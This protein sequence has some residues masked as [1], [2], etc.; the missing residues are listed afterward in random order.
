MAD[1][2]TWNEMEANLQKEPR[3]YSDFVYDTQTDGGCLTKFD[4]IDALI[5]NIND[6]VVGIADK[7]S[8]L[9]DLYQTF[10]DYDETMNTNKQKLQESVNAIKDAYNQVMSG[11]QQQVEELQKNDETLMEDLDNIN[12]LISKDSETDLASLADDVI[13]G[14]YGTGDER[15]AALGDNY[16]AVQDIVNKKLKGEWKEGD[17]PTTDTPTPTTETPTTETPVA[18]TPTTETP[19]VETP[20]TETPSTEVP[21][22]DTT[23]TTPTTEA[24]FM[25]STGQKSLEQLRSELGLFDGVNGNS[26][27]NNKFGSGDLAKN[28]TKVLNDIDIYG[29]SIGLSQKDKSNFAYMIGRESGYKTG[30]SNGQYTGLGQMS[31]GNI[32]TYAVDQNAYKAGNSMVQIDASYK[33]I[34]GRYGSIDNARKHWDSHG[35][36]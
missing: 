13:A 5:G 7:Y 32:S 11:M 25:P 16:E 30:A 20:V 28:Q 31:P 33:Y 23:T 1:V 9:Q 4:E 26:S 2:V 36:Y 19:V 3:T 35:W 21:I 17:T 8:E 12:E 18:E 14:K 6:D 15:K 27:I 34:M 22:T 10:T 29:S 24:G